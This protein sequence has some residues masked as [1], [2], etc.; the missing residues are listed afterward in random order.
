MKDGKIVVLQVIGGLSMGGAESRMMDIAREIDRE[1]FSFDFLLDEPPGYYEPEAVSLGSSIYRVP[2]FY[3]FN[4]HQYASAMDLFFK[5]HKEIDI[6]QASL[7]ST[8]SIYL[9]VA[10]KNGVPVTMAYARSAGVDPGPKGWLTKRLRSTLFEKCDIAAAVSAEAGKAVYG[11]EHADKVMIIPDAFFLDKFKPSADNAAKGLEIRERYS[12]KDRFVIVH[13]G[14][15]HYA[16][17]HEFLLKVFKEIAAKREDA[18]LLLAGD[19]D[20][21]PKMKALAAKEG[22]SDKV[23]FAGQQ[24]D[25]A[26]FYSAGDIM[27]FPSRYEGLPGTVI[28][29]QSSGLPVLMS[30]TITPEVEVTEFVRSLPLAAGVEAWASEALRFYDK[31]NAS[32]PDRGG[33]DNIS[34]LADAGFEIKASV[35]KLEKL[36]EELLEKGGDR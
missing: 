18:A 15:F 14:R 23:I 28:E 36:Y 21:L 5:E 22:I 32:Y 16:K 7:T 6:V 27:I 35:R 25:P 13:V 3:F 11:T 24:S 9:P 34:A 26:A 20:T 33:R 2:R 19:G 29:A 30:D 12:L 31:I 8:A 17:N 4:W 10:K 1:R